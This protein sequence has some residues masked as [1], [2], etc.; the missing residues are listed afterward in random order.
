MD[1]TQVDTILG[2]YSTVTMLLIAIPLAIP[3][4]L[5]VLCADASQ[6]IMRK[7]GHEKTGLYFALGFFFGV[8]G[9]IAA[10]SAPDLVWQRKVLDEL[11]KA[12]G[13]EAEPERPKGNARV[14]VNVEGT[15]SVVA[16]A[17]GRRLDYDRTFARP[18]GMGDRDFAAFVA[19]QVEA[20]LG[21]SVQWSLGLPDEEQAG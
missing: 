19:E 18:A 3:L 2:I 12:N 8:L 4:V 9:L 13:G 7:K 20:D 17:D 6:K 15:P 1:K 21:M 10:N 14:Y 16:I 11:R 5:H